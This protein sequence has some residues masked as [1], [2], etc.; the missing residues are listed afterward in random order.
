MILTVTPNIALDV[1]YQVG[2]LRRHH[3]NRVE[4][5]RAQAGGKGVNV[6]R[7]LA[8]LGREAVVTGLV[9]GPT[10]QAVRAELALAGLPDAL[11]PV[12]AESRRTIAVVDRRAGDVT[13]LNEAGPEITAEEWAGFVRH[14]AAL[15]PACS[16]VVLAGSLPPGVPADA[17]RPLVELARLHRVPVV[18]DASGVPLSAALAAGPDLVKPNADELRESTGT[19]DPYRAAQL[20]RERGA[21]AVVASLGADGMLAVTG[22]G[23]WL[24]RPP[25]RLEGNPTGAGDSAVAALVLGLV[26]GRPWPERLAE[27]VALS[28][29][30]VLSPVAGRFDAAAHRRLLPLVTVG[31][32]GP[33]TGP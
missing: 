17:Y 30:T 24:A 11:L 5:S 32:H 1:T 22:E 7:V 25:E 13:M 12:A 19:A 16:G 27:A 31:R 3:S 8:Q 18:L 29:A 28:A 14:Y 15:L 4:A 23:C 10:G 33:A 6:A 21:Q 9:G 20:L 2:E 26:D